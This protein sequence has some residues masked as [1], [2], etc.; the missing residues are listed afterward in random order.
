MD[1]EL[2]KDP[3]RNFN[4]FEKEA[5]YLNRVLIDNPRIYTLN[6]LRKNK[7]NSPHSYWLKIPNNL[8]NKM[9]VRV[10]KAE[11]DLRVLM[12]RKDILEDE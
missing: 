11:L 7:T 5:R 8:L 1:I 4:T 12:I 10:S 2:E 6:T 9:G 3:Y